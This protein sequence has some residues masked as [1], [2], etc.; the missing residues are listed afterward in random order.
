MRWRSALV[1]GWNGALGL[2]VR[3]LVGMVLSRGT[4]RVRILGTLVSGFL[5]NGRA[6]TS[7]SARQPFRGVFGVNGAS[8]RLLVDKGRGREPGYVRDLRIVVVRFKKVLKNSFVTGGRVRFFRIGR[9]AQWS[10]TAMLGLN[11]SF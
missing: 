7:R 4:G 10:E 1:I 3:V 9:N 6:V 2:T 8:V 11:R 5:N